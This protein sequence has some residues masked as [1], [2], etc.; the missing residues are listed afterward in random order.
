[1]QNFNLKYTMYLLIHLR[2]KMRHLHWFQY[3]TSVVFALFMLIMVYVT[4][5]AYKRQPGSTGQDASEIQKIRYERKQ[6][7]LT[8]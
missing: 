3:V 5:L 1:M 4:Y 7:R 8:R 6:D 2:I